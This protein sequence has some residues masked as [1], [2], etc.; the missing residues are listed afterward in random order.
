MTRALLAALLLLA[1]GA[2]PR[3][4]ATPARKPAVERDEDRIE[5]P[6]RFV[7]PAPEMKKLSALLG[8]WEFTEAW[9]EPVRYKRGAY[10][11]VP[12]EEGSGTLTARPGPGGFSLVLDYEA[13][14]PMGR[15]TAI[16]VV[17]WDPA[18]RLY[19]LDEIHSAFPAV[20]HLTGKFEKGELVFRGK[21][22]RAGEEAAVRLVW[23][24]LGQDAWSAAFSAAEEGGRMERIWSMELSRKPGAP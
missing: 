1:F 15:V 8:S 10:E 18:R 16:A 4:A 23:K 9:T 20:L 21:S 6:V 11:G 7:E 17:A 14:N 3:P 22:G 24:G 2:A 19:E 13:R 5:R 12:G